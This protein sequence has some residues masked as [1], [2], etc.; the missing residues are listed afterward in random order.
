MKNSEVV[1]YLSDLEI[2]H[3][4]SDETG[5]R[6]VSANMNHVSSDYRRDSAADVIAEFMLKPAHPPRSPLK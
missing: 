5:G 2:T 6:L 4:V 3:H 1:C